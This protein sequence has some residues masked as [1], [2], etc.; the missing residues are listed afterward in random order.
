M[1]DPRSQLNNKQKL[2][3][4]LLLICCWAILFGIYWTLFKDI[5]DGLIIFGAGAIGSGVVYV[6]LG[7]INYENE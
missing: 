3:A 1:R 6:W 5:R 2:G 7:F 4:S